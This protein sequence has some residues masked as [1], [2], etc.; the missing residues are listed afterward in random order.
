MRGGRGP[1]VHGPGHEHPIGG[2][3]WERDLPGWLR[4]RRRR[5]QLRRRVFRSLVAAAVVVSAGVYG[6]RELIPEGFGTRMALLVGG[7]LVVFMAVSSMVAKRIARPLEEVARLAD[8]LAAGNL[9]ARIVASPRHGHHRHRDDDATGLRDA[10]NRMADRIETQMNDQRAL[11]AA[12]SHEIRTPLARM[13]ILTEL[14]RAGDGSAL[15]KLDREILESDAL[16]GDLL[17]GS[18]MDFSALKKTRLRASEL[19]TRA[20]EMTEEPIE[21][22]NVASDAEFDGDATLMLRA[23]VNLLENARGHGGGLS[24][25]RVIADGPTLRFEAEDAGP[26]FAAGA[27]ETAFEPFQSG[28]EAP[29]SIGIGLS[30]VRRIAVAHGGRAFAENRSPKGARVTLE[31]GTLG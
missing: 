23:L 8:E 5:G 31:L 2:G 19:A 29:R 21:K 3:P 22:L 7:S 14:A 25:L 6:F 30:L 11:L 12:V 9:S 13:R 26:G 18:R 10:L 20:M 24:E 27:E 4:R 16:V 17:A 28:G 1:H 15:D